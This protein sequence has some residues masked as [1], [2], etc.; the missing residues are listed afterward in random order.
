MKKEMSILREI[1]SE[2]NGRI[3]TTR[4]GFFTLL[5]GALSYIATCLVQGTPIDIGVVLS[6]LGIGTAGKI[7]QKIFEPKE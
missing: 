1:L 5:I 6:L 3:S 2:N 7:G 4:I